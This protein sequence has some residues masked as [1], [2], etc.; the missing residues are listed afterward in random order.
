MYSL[1]NH[2]GESNASRG[3][4]D[5][6]IKLENLIKKAIEKGLKGV[7]ITDHETVGSFIKAKQFEDELDY[8]VICGDEV[9]AVTDQQYDLLKNNYER[10]MYYPHFLLLALDEIGNRMLRE[11]ST[12]AWVD[13]G[14]RTGRLFRTPIKFSDMRKIIGDNKGHLVSSSACLGGQLSKWILDGIENPERIQYRKNQCLDFIQNNKQL[15]GE[16]N[17]FLEIQPPKNKGDDQDLVNNELLKLSK[18]TNT[19]MIV[20]TDSHFL[21]KKDL[22]IHINFL[23]S[24]R[25]NDEDENSQRK[26]EDIYGTCYLMSEDELRQYFYDVGFDKEAL[27]DAINNTDKIGDRAKRYKLEQHQKVPRIEYDDYVLEDSFFPYDGCFK[28]I[29]ESSN[30][31]DKYLLYRIQEGMKKNTQFIDYS[32]TIIRLREEIG[33]VLEISEVLKEHLG[34]YFITMEKLINIIWTEGDSIVGVARGSCASSIIAF[35]LGIIQINPLKMPVDM[36]FWRFITPS[37]IEIADIDIDTQSNRRIQIFKAVR[38]YFVDRGGDVVNCCTYG[39]IGSKSAVQV[40][41]RGLGIDTDILHQITDCIP[42]NRGFV[43]NL[44]DT[45]HGNEEEGLSPV[46]EFVSLIDAQDN[47]LETALLIESVIISRG[48]HASGIFITNDEFVNY[49]AKMRTASGGIVSQWDLHDSEKNGL[50]KYDFLTT[51]ACTKIRLTLDMLVENGHVEE[52]NTLRETYDSILH[53]HIMNYDTKEIWETIGNNTM[54]DLFQ[55]STPIAMQ[56]VGDIKPSNLIELSQSNSLMRLQKQPDAIETPTETYV[57]FK[58]NI[59]EWYKEMDEWNVPKK[60]QEMLSSVLL[61]YNGVAES[62]EAIMILSQLNGLSN[63][64]VA[65]SHKLRKSIAKKSEKIYNEI[66]ELFYKKCEENNVDKHTR[67][68]VWNVQVNRQKLYSFSTLH[69]IVYSL[70]G[71]QELVL[72][73]Q[74]PSI[75]WNTACLTVNAGAVEDDDEDASKKSTDYGKVATAIGKLKEQ[76][77]NISLPHIN[78]AHFKFYA[79]ENRDQIIFG[80]KGI[81][82]ISDDVATDIIEN[83][84][85]KSMLDF[86]ERMV[87][88]KREIKTSSGNTQNQSIV[89]SSKVFTLIK[90]GCFDKIEDKT[91]IGVMNDYMDIIYPHKTKFNSKGIDQVAEFGIIPNELSSEQKVYNFR[92][93]LTNKLKF[94]KK[95]IVNEKETKNRSWHKLEGDSEGATEYVINYFS[96]EFISDMKEDEDYYYNEYGDMLVCIGGSSKFEKIYKEKTKKIMKWLNSPDCL[97]RYNKIIRNGWLLKHAEGSVSKWEMDSL[98]FYYHEHELISVDEEKYG[99]ENFLDIPNSN[100]YTVE[101]KE[102][103]PFSVYKEVKYPKFPLSRLVGTI[104]DKNKDKH[105][106]T[107]LT[108]YGVVLLKFY[109]GQFGHYNKQISM[110]NDDGTKTTIEKGWFTRGNKILVTGYRRGDQF[111]PKIYKGDAFQHT[112]SLIENVREDGSLEMKTDRTRVE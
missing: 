60:D 98:S 35:L 89:S 81:V 28:Q 42:I 46:K 59:S 78:E 32:E 88:V 99:I 7:A 18:E 65:E 5:S 100:D 11:I 63:F 6:S 22:P 47:L 56:T 74:Y 27:N 2:G 85:Y 80:L 43:Q 109:A 40:A 38:E 58:N 8:P 91:R 96:E 71:L 39:T 55:F 37:R 112:V 17:F 13:N 26:L 25:D 102:S 64:S 41:G 31:D 10:E 90:A 87:M 111:K 12:T 103:F 61:I 104:L 24:S 66:S 82:D 83:R 108:V 3:F 14:Y 79:D 34:A 95:Y 20:T 44:E 51:E 105:S 106:V 54:M 23:S 68:Y 45:Y 86:H 30:E 97:D 29:L 57:R 33:A 75:Y 62:Q 94:Y 52:K 69:S 67:N 93:F 19:P 110:V 84:P 101:E 76:G 72:Y 4:A 36:P 70:I 77:I 9:Y 92:K 53:P 73:T 15:F 107:L 1:H 49:N 48:Q 21:D 50:L 16:G